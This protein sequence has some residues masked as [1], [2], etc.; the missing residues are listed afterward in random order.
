MMMVAAPLLPG[1]AARMVADAV[2]DADAGGGSRPGGG[3]GVRK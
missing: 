2:V 3:D 1:A